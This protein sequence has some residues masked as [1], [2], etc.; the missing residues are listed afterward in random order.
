MLK[1]CLYTSKRDRRLNVAFTSLPLRQ[2]SSATQT[3]LRGRFSRRAQSVEGA[4]SVEHRQTTLWGPANGDPPRWFRYKP[5]SS[6]GSQSSRPK[7]IAWPSAIYNRQHGMFFSQKPSTSL[8]Q[9]LDERIFKLP[10]DAKLTWAIFI[11]IFCLLPGVENAIK[12]GKF[13]LYL[14]Y[15][16]CFPES[17]IWCVSYIP[18]AQFNNVHAVPT[19]AN[20][21][22]STCFIH[23]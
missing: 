12:L 8:E 11:N 17:L 22:A 3:E 16:L 1:V 2:L 10:F 20:Y 13:S 7:T 6:C 4:D 5:N 14:S 18:S 19:P 23:V 9:I 15:L 21:S